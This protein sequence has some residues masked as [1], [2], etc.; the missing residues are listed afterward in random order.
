M[1]L[2]GGETTEAISLAI[3]NDEIAALLGVGRNDMI[4][5]PL[6]TLTSVNL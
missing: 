2:R 5:Q 1:S 6:P 4:T 3:E